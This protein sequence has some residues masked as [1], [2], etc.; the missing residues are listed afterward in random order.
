MDAQTLQDRISKGMGLAAR[1]A[2]CAFTVYRPRD[3]ADPLGA[4]NRVIDLWAMF[5]AGRSGNS[6]SAV[7]EG[8]YDF[9]YTQPGDYLVGADG[10]YFVA[11]QRPGLPVL[12]VLT[13]R[14]VSLV[15]PLP[16]MQGGYGG[17][18]AVPGE[19]LIVSWP[20]CLLEAG[21][22]AEVGR[23]GETRF[24]SWSLMLPV[25]PL[26]PQIA[27]VVSDDLGGAYVVGS[28]EQNALG[29]RLLVRQTS[30]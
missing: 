15:R 8:V 22:H 12:C 18:F 9:S 10:T 27:D 25:L 6:S 26:A 23:A 16:A 2:G 24:G 3:A 1:R 11:S 28:A 5:T 30:A 14:V 13:N 20:A 7:W 19:S 21:G 17:F 29:W 4:R